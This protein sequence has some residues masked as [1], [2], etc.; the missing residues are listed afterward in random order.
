L[1]LSPKA[2]ISLSTLSVPELSFKV[3]GDGREG[4]ADGDREELEILGIEPVHP[5]FMRESVEV[6][7]R[8]STRV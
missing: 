2:S 3:K 8:A 4:E 7:Q 5:D 6:S 1:N